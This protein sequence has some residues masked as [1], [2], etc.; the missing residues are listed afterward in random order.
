MRDY[1]VDV[2][3]LARPHR[4]DPRLAEAWDLIIGG[5]EIAPAYSELVDPVVDPT[6]WRLSVSGLVEHPLSVSY[7]ALKRFPAQER[8]QTLECISNKV[9]GHLMSTAKWIGVPVS[10]ILGRARVRSAAV[11]VVFRS[12]SGYADS[13]SIDQAMDPSTLIATNLE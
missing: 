3:P 13:L 9:G 7:D 12:V 2:R 1:P 11:E 8:Y 10:E 6:S 4:D 5:V